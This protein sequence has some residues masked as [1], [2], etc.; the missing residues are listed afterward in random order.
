MRLF[1]A[2]H[3]MLPAMMRISCRPAQCTRLAS[4]LAG[5]A[6]TTA[7]RYNAGFGPIGDNG[8]LEAQNA[9]LSFDLDRLE[10]VVGLRMG[11]FG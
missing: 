5:F 3:A 2:Q 7:C 11:V 6:S 1:I 10:A 4:Q 9:C 8:Q